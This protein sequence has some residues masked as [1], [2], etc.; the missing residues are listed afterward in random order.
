MTRLHQR[1]PVHL[2]EEPLF[3]DINAPELRISVGRGGVPVVT[4][5]LPLGLD[6]AGVTLVQKELLDQYLIDE[7]IGNF[8]AWYYTPMALKFTHHLCPELTV[9]DCMDELSA[10][11]G[12][13]PELL[14]LEK[15]L[16]VRADVV[17]TGGASL[18]A[19]KRSRHRNVHLFPSSIDQA[20]FGA[21]RLPMEDRS[22]QAQ[23]PHP[24][25]GFFG[26]LDE[27]L[28]R[29]LL[30]AVAKERPKWHFVLVGPV[31][32]IRQEDLP[33]AGNIHY[34]GQKDYT[35]LAAYVANW[36]VAML[37]FAQNASTKFISPTKTPEYLAAGKPVVSTPI[38]DV[39]SPYGELGLVKIGKDAVEFGA[40][41]EACLGIVDRNEWLDQ[42]DEFLADTSWDKTFE[43]MWK[44]VQWCKPLDTASSAVKMLNMGA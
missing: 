15:E 19:S 30:R 10:F 11:D 32:K 3:E 2:W 17:F 24:R 44:E 8:V 31:M 21:A 6:D 36:D 38:R 16:F 7:R 29:E 4:P 22:D 42:V 23:I 20:Y 35:D 12:A 33:R 14:E 13:P 9:Y 26:V 39:V 25:I 1:A 34:L 28:D 18:Y 27:R 40:A 5:L 37:P 41:I 43:S